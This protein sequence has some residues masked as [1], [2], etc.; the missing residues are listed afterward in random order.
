MTLYSGIRVHPPGA[1]PFF[2]AEFRSWFDPET[3][4]NWLTT[5]APLYLA[6][7]FHPDGRYVLV[8]GET[9]IWSAETMIR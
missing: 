3:A 4:L 2:V 1:P 7:Q 5:R 9:V 6:A 8:Q